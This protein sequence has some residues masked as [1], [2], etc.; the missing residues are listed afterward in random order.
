MSLW[1]QGGEISKSYLLR[2]EKRQQKGVHGVSAIE[3]A[4]EAPPSG[5]HHQAIRQPFTS[6]LGF[7]LTVLLCIFVHFYQFCNISGWLL[8]LCTS[9]HAQWC[10]CGGVRGEVGLGVGCNMHLTF[11]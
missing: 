6:V 3:A 11:L 10:V 1:K 8:D 9:T 7:R 2:H 5:H 4:H